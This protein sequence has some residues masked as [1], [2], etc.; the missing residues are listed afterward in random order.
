VKSGED[1]KENEIV[2]LL[3]LLSRVIG[4]RG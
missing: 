4:D 1:L 3:W 2:G